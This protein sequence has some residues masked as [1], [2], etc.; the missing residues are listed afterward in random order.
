MS[1]SRQRSARVAKLVGV[2][3]AFLPW[4]AAFADQITWTN[5]S[6]DSNWL[7]SA[8]WSG[9]SGQQV[10]GFSD[11][12]KLT[13]QAA[14]AIHLFGSTQVTEL[15]FSNFSAYNIDG[16]GT[17][18]LLGI[19]AQNAF[20][21]NTLS[22]NIND[23][24]GTPL[25]IV[26]GGRLIL[27]G[28]IHASGATFHG[29]GTTE[30]HGA[31]NDF[32]FNTSIDIA[33][34]TV[35]AYGSG[36]LGINTVRLQGGTL[37]LVDDSNAPNGTQVAHYGNVIDVTSDSQLAYGAAAT[38]F[39]PNAPPNSNFAVDTVRLGAAR[40]SIVNRGPNFN[41]APGTLS[42]DLLN[43]TGD[44]TLVGTPRGFHV[45]QSVVN[46]QSIV[47]GNPGYAI[48]FTGGGKFLVTGDGGHSGTNTITDQAVVE[49]QGAGSLGS[50]STH[51][52]AGGTLLLDNGLPFNAG[53]IHVAASGI[54]G[55]TNL[56]SVNFGSNVVLE[57]N[58]II[59]A[60]G[61][62]L[63]TLPG[64][65]GAP[66]PQYYLGAD[67]SNGTYTVGENAADDSIFK[68]LA[69]GSFTASH[70]VSAIPTIPTSTRFVGTAQT[71]RSGDPLLISCSGY[72]EFGDPPSDPG[73]LPPTLP[74]HATFNT[75]G[76]TV[77]I[78]HPGGQVSW[79]TSPAGDARQF[80][81]YGNQPVAAEAADIVPSG[82]TFTIHGGYFRNYY[83]RTAVNAGGTVVIAA[84]GAMDNDL[85]PS[86]GA[87]HI[88]AGGL[89]NVSD[90][91]STPTHGAVFSY[92]T[93]ALISLN[94][95]SGGL[96]L[97]SPTWLPNNADLIVESAF[98][99][100]TGD[101][102]T[103]GQGRRLTVSP[104][105]SAVVGDGTNRVSAF[106]GATSVILAGSTQT[107][108]TINDR[109]DLAGVNVQIG[110]TGTFHS[111]TLYGP[112]NFA[113][114]DQVGS[115]VLTAPNNRVG[116]LSVVAGKLVVSGTLTVD[117]I[118]IGNT[119]TLSGAQTITASHVDVGGTISPGYSPGLLPIVGNLNLLPGSD[120]VWEISS[121]HG[122]AG[123]PIGWDLITVDGT[124][125]I[126]GT[127]LNPAVVSLR[128]LNLTDFDPS[129]N[130]SFTIATADTI[131]GF[132]LTHMV[133]DRTGFDFTG[134]QFVLQRV[135]GGGADALNL[136]YFN[137]VATPEPAT[138]LL[139]P[140]ALL[141]GNLR[142]RRAI[143]V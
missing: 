39:S 33:S 50:G 71:A 43:L 78:D 131:T 82:Y 121:A 1:N 55:G 63:A 31:S 70:T 123:D 35:D 106:P 26:A 57:D 143:R 30:L 7:T 74:A 100:F 72:V 60:S 113:D 25:D 62:A 110:A 127:A 46:I 9:P 36:A 68:G 66:S 19:N 27:N 104:G 101:G 24:S 4:S 91:E 6:G 130:A 76:A 44:G 64:R 58:A 118:N 48:T 137:D 2:V 38:A 40:L 75:G 22:V 87:F 108:L 18:T 142:R 52:D 14:G 114:I 94:T 129:Q 59:V 97:G 41:S 3:A 56:T 98:G 79:F 5:N 117:A 105:G 122:L 116:V 119:G 13:D 53:P 138:L 109:L 132:S 23:F 135:T 90:T 37:R 111:A 83:S 10:P 49:L 102:I 103:L 128:S 107:P 16:G 89:L 21:S 80:D 99:D 112:N 61:T 8:N 51:I 73:V 139:A 12:A 115:V 93:G 42:I 92:D 54:I 29:F 45:E 28:T 136:V 47:D 95:N 81:F 84:G 86:T 124:L 141:V 126:Q 11:I 134:G 120:Y 85:D 133:I 67:N 15:N 69:I 34:G 20:A 96:N 32:G 88:N 140:V 65:N 125:A 17:I 77:R